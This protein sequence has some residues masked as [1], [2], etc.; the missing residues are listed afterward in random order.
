[1]APARRLVRR[2][3]VR[4]YA[5][6]VRARHSARAGRRLYYVVTGQFAFL[7]NARRQRAQLRALR[8]PAKVGSASPKAPA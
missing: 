4:G 8:L 7:A 2:L 5:P 3:E 1:V 6:V